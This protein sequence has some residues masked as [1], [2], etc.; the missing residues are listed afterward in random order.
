MPLALGSI[1]DALCHFGR[2]SKPLGA[3]GPVGFTATMPWLITFYRDSRAFI[4]EFCLIAP[5]LT[6]F[7]KETAMYS[8]TISAS[9]ATQS[10][11]EGDREL[12]ASLVKLLQTAFKEVD[13]NREAAKA[14]IAK[15]SSLLQVQIERSAVTP[16]G[17]RASGGLL[18]WQIQRVV[19]FI[20]KHLKEPL[21]VEDLS[22]VVSL[23]T[24]YFSRSFRRSFGEAPY[25]Y[26]TRRR[27]EHARHLML[28]SDIALSE[29][30]LA[31]GFADQAHLGRQFRQRVGASPAAW[32][33]QRRQRNA[34]K[35]R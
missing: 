14:V 3:R 35:S 28:T 6:T 8:S 9:E 5:I 16:V 12:V 21:R 13:T 25:A 23:S 1:N 30:A 7:L 29:V 26:L 4:G 15:A 2:A 34:C 18:A 11:T 22:Q 32:R 24:A 33:R 27:V 19:G 31:C 20:D 10:F 17:G